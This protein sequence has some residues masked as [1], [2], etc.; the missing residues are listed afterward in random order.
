M[1]RSMPCNHEKLPE[2]EAIAIVHFLMFESVLG[3]AF[4][5]RKNLRPFNTRTQ[6]ARTAHQVGV[7]MRL[8]NMRNRETCFARHVNVNIAVRSRIENRGDAF[9]IISDKIR[10]LG[11]TFG[12]NGFENERHLDQLKRRRVGVQQDRYRAL[13]KLQLVAAAYDRRNYWI[14]RS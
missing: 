5:T 6:L 1:T 3:A 11:D 12:L 8:K 9:V 2:G 4:V 7:N 14:R 13:R 10:K